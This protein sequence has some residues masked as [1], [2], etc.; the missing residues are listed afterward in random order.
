VELRLVEHG[1]KK[2]KDGKPVDVKIIKARDV[3]ELSE[4]NISKEEL[5]LS[6]IP[7]DERPKKSVLKQLKE[8][9]L[10]DLRL[11]EQKD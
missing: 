1:V 4:I 6:L 3:E 10:F 8:Y 11:E 2:G 5:R 9:Q 7:M